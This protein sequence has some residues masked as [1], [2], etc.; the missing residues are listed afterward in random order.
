MTSEIVDPLCCS[1]QVPGRR[2]SVDTLFSLR[3]FPVSFLFSQWA[4]NLGVAMSVKASMKKYHGIISLRIPPKPGTSP[5]SCSKSLSS[6]A[7]SQLENQKSG[8]K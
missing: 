6:A 3:L 7:I 2:S 4:S 8:N 1:A 5:R